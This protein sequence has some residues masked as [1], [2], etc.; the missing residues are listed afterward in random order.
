MNQDCRGRARLVSLLVLKT[1]IQ[2]FEFLFMK[3]WRKEDLICGINFS[4]NFLLAYI[5]KTIQCITMFG[6]YSVRKTRYVKRKRWKK[7]FEKLNCPDYLIIRL[8]L[9]VKIIKKRI[10]SIF[11]FYFLNSYHICLC[12]YNFFPPLGYFD[13]S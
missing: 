10:Y 13:F 11:I 9:K 7:Q 3:L 1:M 8:W 2:R 5:W 4:R 6:H 12:I